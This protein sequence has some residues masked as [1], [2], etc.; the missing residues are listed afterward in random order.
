MSFGKTTR[1]FKG[2]KNR[3]KLGIAVR[4]KWQSSTIYGNNIDFWLKGNHH[5]GDMWI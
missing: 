3:S 1:L 2:N 5:Y 4:T